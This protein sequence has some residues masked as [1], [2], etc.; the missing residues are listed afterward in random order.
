MNSIT[1][2]EL[3][4]ILEDEILPRVEKP[5]RYLGCEVNA[6]RKEAAPGDVRIALAFP[7]LYDLGLP[8]LG[9]LILYDI[10]NRREGVH[11][12]R[13]Y[14]PGLDLEAIL[15]ERRLPLFSLESRT[16]LAQFD[17]IGF[18][19]QYELCYTNL[20]NMLDLAGIPLQSSQR[21]GS[22]RSSWPAA[23]ARST[24]SHSPISS[25]PSRLA[26]ARR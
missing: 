18:T 8:N 22:P 25:M 5:S 1:A 6:T 2:S 3:S 13:V 11:A 19:L 17:C 24:P 7:D 14:A 4:R 10:L 26:M 9:L 12:E 21:D 15:R 20:L 16:P 23:R